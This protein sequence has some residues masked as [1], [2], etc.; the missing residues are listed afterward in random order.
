[1]ISDSVTLGDD[2][3]LTAELSAPDLGSVYRDHYC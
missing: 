3:R 2:F 1:M